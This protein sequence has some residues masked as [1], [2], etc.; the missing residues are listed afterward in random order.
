MRGEKL[1]R[2]LIFAVITILTMIAGCKKNAP[3]SESKELIIFHA[4]S[5]SVPFRKI[6]R[7]FNK[8]YPDIHIK[9]EAAGSRSCA[10]KICDLK[11]QCDVM[12][13]ADY[14]VVSSLLM[15]EYADYNICFAMNEMVIACT[16]RSNYNEQINAENWNEILLQDDVAFGRSDPNLDPC[17]Y[18]TLILFQLAEKYYEVS[19]LAEQLR[20]KTDCVRP[21][22][23]DLLGLLEAGEIDYLF[24]Y[25]S[26]A[27]Q[28]GLNTIL[29]PDQINLKNEAFAS[30]YKTATV[31]LSGKEPGRF[32]TRCGESMIYSVTIP[33]T[34]AN[35]ESAELWVAFLLS[36]RGRTIMA[37]YGQPCLVPAEV[38]HYE[39]LPNILKQYC[40]KKE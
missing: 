20:Q 4:G 1:K 31:K 27:A 7:E 29:L 12:A 13:S 15:P 26:V 39:E 19:G 36:E 16:D 2:Y 8:L 18:R 23:T 40:R 11:R 37:Q 3:S 34:A 10:R 17:G 6:S 25:R 30:F 24:I 35:A 5:L 14:N 21:K 33:K 28:H 32:I 22:E 38:T 9:A